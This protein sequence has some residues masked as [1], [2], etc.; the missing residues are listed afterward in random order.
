MVSSIHA[1]PVSRSDQYKRVMKPLLERKRRAR[2][3]RCLDE[4]RDLLV[5]VLQSEGEAVTRL[6]KADILE[7]TVRHVRRLSQRRR[8]AI[9]TPSSRQQEEREDVTKFQQG[10]VAAAQQVHTFLMNTNSLE[11]A[12]SSRLLSHLTSCATSITPTPPPVVS[13]NSLP[14]P[15][16]PASNIPVRGQSSNVKAVVPIRS[17]VNPSAAVNPSIVPAVNS[18]GV[19]ASYI[20]S[21][22]K[23]FSKPLVPGVVDQPINS[24]CSVP[25]QIRMKATNQQLVELSDQKSS[26]T[27]LTPINRD[28]PMPAVAPSP[29][30]DVVSTEYEF[31][32]PSKLGIKSEF[33][34]RSPQEPNFT[35]QLHAKF[36]P[37]NSSPR[38]FDSPGSETDSDS[39]CASPSPQDLSMKKN[40]EESGSSWRPW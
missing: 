12:I 24:Q 28:I 10:F 33:S 6:E 13:P 18:S 30:I 5:S 16:L 19:L 25:Y 15:P 40:I 27:M 11:P 38:M 36:L 20:P 31:S 9:P 35:L 17:P 3:N 39:S 21:G 26:N 4:L 32:E 34:L 14:Q 8:L 22:S 37:R 1:E 7:L 23:N 2:I 29:F